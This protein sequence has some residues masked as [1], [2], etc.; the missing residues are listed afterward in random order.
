MKIEDFENVENIEDLGFI[1]LRH[2]NN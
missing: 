2:V 1:I